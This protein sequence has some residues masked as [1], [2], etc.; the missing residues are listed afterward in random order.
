MM[1]ATGTHSSGLLASSP[2]SASSAVA[3]IRNSSGG[4]MGEEDDIVASLNLPYTVCEVLV[5]VMAVIGNAL[6]IVV[7]V[8][9][10]RLRRLTNYYIVSLALAD[11]LVGMPGIPFAILTSVGIPHNSYMCPPMLSL[12]LMLCTVS[13]FCLVAVSVDR[14]WAIL[15]PLRYSRVMTAK[16]ARR[17]ILLCWL[18]GIFLGFLPLMGWRQE[19]E[20]GCYFVKVMDYNYLVFIYFSTIV[21]PGILMAFFY[22][23]IY[24]VVLKQ[25]RQIAAQEPQS[26]AGS[27]CTQH[28]GS[29]RQRP[30]FLVS[31]NQSRSQSEVNRC[32]SRR[33]STSTNVVH[34]PPIPRTSKLWP[35][36]PFT[37]RCLHP[38]DF[39]QHSSLRHLGPTSPS[40]EG[41]TDTTLRT[42]SPSCQTLLHSNHRNHNHHYHQQ[43]VHQQHSS[44]FDLRNHQEESLHHSLLRHNFEGALKRSSEELRSKSTRTLAEDERT[45]LGKEEVKNPEGTEKRKCLLSNSQEPSRNQSKEAEEELGEKEEDAEEKEEEEEDLCAMTPMIRISKV[46]PEAE[47]LGTPSDDLTSARPFK[48]DKPAKR[49]LGDRTPEKSS[50]CTKDN[51]GSRSPRRSEDAGSRRSSTLSYVLYQVTHANKREVKAAKSLSIIVLFFLICWFP[52]YTINFAQS[53]CPRC[54]LVTPEA[55]YFT[56]ILTHVNSAVNPFLYAYHMKDFRHALKTFILEKILRRKAQSEPL[57]HRSLVSPHHSTLYRVAVGGGSPQL[58]N[59]HTPH[60]HNTPIQSSSS[61]VAGTPSGNRSRSSTLGSYGHWL[62][63]KGVSSTVSLGK[64]PEDKDEPLCRP[65]AATI[66]SHTSPASVHSAE[67]ACL[68]KPLLSASNLLTLT[69]ESCGGGEITEHQTVSS[70]SDAVTINFSATDPTEVVIGF[71]QYSD[72]LSAITDDSFDQ[73]VRVIP[74]LQLNDSKLPP[75]N[76]TPLSDAYQNSTTPLTAESSLEFVRKIADSTELSSASGG[77]ELAFYSRNITSEATYNRPMGRNAN[78]E[79]ECPLG[80]AKCLS[81]HDMCDLE[82]SITDDGKRL[83]ESTL[84]QNCLTRENKPNGTDHSINSSGGKRLA[85]SEINVSQIPNGTEDNITSSSTGKYES[86]NNCDVLS[87]RK[88]SEIMRLE[89]TPKQPRKHEAT[90][91]ESS[92]LSQEFYRYLPKMLRKKDENKK[93]KSARTGK[94]WLSSMMRNRSYHGLSVE[95]AGSKQLP[96]AKSIS[97]AMDT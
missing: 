74:T 45:A 53:F 32:D 27:V 13:I 43:T 77:D 84:S 34:Q 50:A 59:F 88:E 51:H 49:F 80:S 75:G 86:T 23:H 97:G 28:G 90:T 57:S 1:N 47:G 92:P 96:R 72:G 6:T 73:Q 76:T 33:C 70:S 46:K 5:A 91:D 3:D 48:N 71:D 52:L 41:T 30:H 40:D 67:E 10:R 63:S 4:A 22:T 87:K 20:G 95:V 18:A 14:Y 81:D 78:C 66:T 79:S 56:I 68:K 29:Q 17:I 11:L 26:E 60:T 12:L 31:R 55:M 65:R 61:P 58:A 25:L 83:S 24:T 93:S 82:R 36:K 38:L 19:H 54:T 64:T 35:P 37:R 2:S 39:F 21:F 69:H 89:E 62:Q 85:A 16:I 42:T 8:K 9:E 7:F 44:L 15:Y 94:G